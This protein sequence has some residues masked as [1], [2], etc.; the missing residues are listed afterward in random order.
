MQS[1]IDLLSLLTP[2]DWFI[3]FFIAALTV[4]FVIWGQLKKKKSNNEDEN[5][6]DLMLMGRGLT[7]PMFVAT[8]VATWYGGIFGVSQIAFEHGIFNFVTQGLFWY[9]AYIIF[10]LFITS[11]IKNYKAMTL[12][13]LVGQM[14]G[15]KAEKISALLN[16]INLIPI[17][18]AISIGLLIKMLFGY[19]LYISVSLGVSFVLAYSV[20]GGFRAVVFS[21]IVQFFVMCSSVIGI[22]IISIITFGLTPLKN[23]P[24]SYFDPTGGYSILQTLSWGL[25]AISTLVDPNFYQRTFAAQ[26]L[27]VAKRGILISTAIWFVFDISLT[28]GAMYARAVI[29]HASSEFGYFIYSMQ[30]LPNGLRGFAL[31]GI[32]ATVLSTLDSYIF[33]AGSTLAYDLAPKRLKGKVAIHHLGIVLVGVMAVIFSLIFSGDIKNVW[34]TLGSLSSS[35][36]LVP[37]LLGHLYKKRFS[38]KHFITSSLLGA[39]GAFSW[40]LS[41]FKDFYQLDEIY[42]GIAMSLIGFLFV[43]AFSTKKF[44]STNNS[45]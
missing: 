29:P 39:S 8:L 14:F 11:R 15:P 13:D 44:K 33:L 27:K 6:I 41:G 32:A 28:F 7:L 38:D 4:A 17:A 18:Y 26:N 23:L 24:E 45:E 30:L 25:I 3:F 35:S 21:D 10:A 5:F 20:F 12:P 40:R 16:F 42:I 22:F 34:K 1:Q 19:E 36:L 31:A 37:V 9:V 43:E 2:L